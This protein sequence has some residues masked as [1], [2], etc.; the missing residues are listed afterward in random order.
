MK[1][2]INQ[3]IE[4]VRAGAA[5]D[6]QNVETSAAGTEAEITI[7]QRFQ[8]LMRDKEE[9]QETFKSLS[10]KAS[11][12]CDNNF[13][14]SFAENIIT[15]NKRLEFLAPQ[16]AA[17]EWMRK[18]LPQLLEEIKKRTVGAVEANTARFVSE[19]KALL[20]KHEIM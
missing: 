11:E 12:Y 4:K 1:Q 9:A 5:A 16:M 6:R 10:A 18:H 13:L 14:P 15:D 19:H 2:S 3:I 7:I 8:Q 20:Q 17:R